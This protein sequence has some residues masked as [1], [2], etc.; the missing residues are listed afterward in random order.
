MSD[1][2]RER[3]LKL[4]LAGLL[5]DVGKMKLRA[6]E[7]GASRTWDDE[8]KRDYGRFHALLTY[9]IVGDWLPPFQDSEAVKNWAAQHHRP[10]K[11][12]DHLVR[13]ADRLSS[14]EREK[15]DPD[16]EMATQ[17]KQLLS[18]FCVVNADN[19]NNLDKLY[20][21]LRALDLNEQTTDEQWFPG[22]EWAKTD[23]DRSYQNL[24]KELNEQAQNLRQAHANGGDLETYLE[25]LLY[26]MQRYT[27][28][29]P[30]AYYHSLPD[31]SLYD[32]SRMTAALAAVLDDLALSDEELRA[33]AQA[34]QESDTPVALLVGGD[35][36]GV[37]DFIY[38]ITDRGATSA[39]R[40]RSF[41]L[42]LLTEAAAHYILRRLD[43]PITNLIYAGG[44]NFY[45]LARAND[46]ADLNRI[47]LDISRILYN[48]HQGD[49][50]L[51]VA[52]LPLAARDFF[53]GRIS[54]KWQELGE[55]LQVVK[56]QRFVELPASDL[57]CLFEPQ[58]RGGN[59]EK[60]CSVCGREYEDVHPDKNNPA[61][62]KCKA[63]ESFEEEIGDPLRKA[64]YLVWDFE[65]Q[66]P[67]PPDG[68]RSSN[69]SSPWKA[70]LK[71]LGAHV[72]IEATLEE[73]HEPK[74]RRLILAL[75][76]KSLNTLKPAAQ[77]A[78]GRRLLVN[79]TP[80]V[81]AE[82]VSKYGK[83]YQ[84]RTG[85]SLKEGAVKPFELMSMQAIGIER[86]GV[87]RMDVD[88]LGQL[89][90]QGLGEKATLS[91]VAALSFAI[92]LYFEGWVG[93]LARKRNQTQGDRL[94]AIYSGGDDLFFVGAWD[95]VV[96]LG[97]EIRRDLTPYAA[98]HPG[99]HTSAGIVLIGGK[100]PL[101]QAAQDAGRAEEAAKRHKWWDDNSD[102][103]HTKDAICFLGRVLPW[104][105][106]GMKKS[107]T[108]SF[109][110]AYDTLAFLEDLLARQK[111]SRSLIRTLLR[112]DERYQEA[113]DVR[114]RTGRDLGEN[115]RPQPL[116]GPW[117][118]LFEYQLA[119]LQRMYEEQL[120]IKSNLETL[121][122]E[123]KEAFHQRIEWVSLAARWAELKMRKGDQSEH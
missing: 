108:V 83:E 66:L 89:F 8:A 49:L 52:G 38:T 88:N 25:S 9:D 43:L 21:P 73:L 31:I 104:Q 118:W 92:S 123:M 116:W 111:A 85:Q 95:E 14:G 121:C 51:A 17:P 11:R 120:E 77:I 78:V 63:C 46:T 100:Y 69:T 110:T 70:V 68:V 82:D 54:S 61:V 65:P 122:Q 37:Q 15:T 101:A 39:L 105:R 117:N 4:A 47:R 7:S 53:A 13:L 59:E 5:H 76:E 30:S 33:L 6:G 23:V 94:Y 16:D 48:H 109:E 20:W 42:Q 35:L 74:G 2:R 26:L 18:I 64:R 50:Y 41:Y 97:R 119:R 19:Q 113:M 106:F 87:L 34:P 93:V 98:K 44:G 114:R 75:D 112:L 84:I 99:I 29:V 12:E 56:K 45:L 90:A 22:Q 62:R 32:H 91:R 80:L 72:H 1:E 57:A 58:G 36:S 24:W 81:T 86:L 10:N 107:A 28:S 27:W 102:T 79:V 103:P 40:G 55:L 71:N 67:T 60:Q 3:A 96:E 115:H